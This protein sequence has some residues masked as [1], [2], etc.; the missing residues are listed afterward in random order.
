MVNIEADVTVGRILKKLAAEAG[1][2]YTVSSG[3]RT[4]LPDGAD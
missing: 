1:V 4:G 2:L 3:R